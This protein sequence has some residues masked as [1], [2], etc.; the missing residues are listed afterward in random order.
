MSEAKVFK[1]AQKP[2]HCKSS[3][4]VKDQ[5]VAHTSCVNMSKQPPTQLPRYEQHAACL[6]TG[7]TAGTAGSEA[8]QSTLTST[9]KQ[10][11][12]MHTADDGMATIGTVGFGALYVLNMKSQL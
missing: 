7:A 10:D 12:T 3:K 9:Q 1:V 6:D 4:K 5:K 11:V 8:I 2:L